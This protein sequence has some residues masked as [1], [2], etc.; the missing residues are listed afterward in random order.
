MKKKLLISFMLGIFGIAEGYQLTGIEGYDENGKTRIVISTQ[1]MPQYRAFVILNPPRL[2]ID[3]LN[4]EDLISKERI[5]N[6]SNALLSISSQ[7]RLKEPVKIARVTIGLKQVFPYQLLSDKNNVIIELDTGLVRKEAPKKIEVK[8]EPIEIPKEGILPQLGK[9][10]EA[11]K[12][13]EEIKEEKGTEAFISMRFYETDILDV[14]RAL[15]KKI[16]R[17][18]VAGPD[19]SGVVT[20]ELNKVRYDQALDMILKPHN[21]AWVSEEG[22]IRVDTRENLLK[23]AVRTE[24]VP[25]NYDKAEDMVK[26]VEPLLDPDAGGKIAVD[27]R[28]NSLIITTTSQNLDQIKGVIKSL[29]APTPQVMI[30]SKMVQVDLN[31]VKNLGIDWGFTH[32]SS[33]ED[34]TSAKVTLPSGPAQMN[35]GRLTGN[36]L[37]FFKLDNL[38]TKKKAEVVASPKV[39]TSDNQ[40]AIIKVGQQLPYGETTPS[41]EGG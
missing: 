22:I 28:T 30:E 39:T 38:I 32:P 23:T 4:A 17:N 36:T 27:K 19:V 40:K 12:L 33:A 25:I 11:I 9:I 3:L 13:K 10:E 7:Q 5:K 41:A 6:R 15:S 16:E 8:E 21:F 35:I 31:E 24:V 2:I 37:L 14:L 18:I 1:E 26:N 34:Y 20:I 29:D